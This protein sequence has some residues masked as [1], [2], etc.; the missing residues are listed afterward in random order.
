[1]DV[2]AVVVFG[3]IFLLGGKGCILGILIGVLII[4]VL[5]NG[6]NIIG[7]LVFW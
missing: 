3:G 2:I 4:G 5:N 1:M 6:F 7:V